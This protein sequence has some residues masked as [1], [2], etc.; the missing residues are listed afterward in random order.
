MSQNSA[1]RDE[2]QLAFW[3]TRRA[4]EWERGASSLIR[5]FRFAEA[6]IHIHE[7]IEFTVKALCR[8]MRVSFPKEHV[9]AVESLL[10]LSE[11]VGALWPESRVSILQSAPVLLGYSE[12]LRNVAR[13]GLEG[14]E[15]SS[16]SPELAFGRDYCSAGLSALSPL[17]TILTRVQLAARWGG[18]PVT[19]GVLDSRLEDSSIPCIP[20]WSKSCPSD[21]ASWSTILGPDYKVELVR[22]PDLDEHFAAVIDPF[23]ETYPEYDT[24][25][26]PCF[27]R[28]LSFIENGGLLVTSAGLP[29]YAA[30]DHK[31]GRDT[32]ITD[33][34]GYLIAQPPAPQPA[35]VVL[36]Y[37]LVVI[38]GTIPAKVFGIVPTINDGGVDEPLPLLMNRA[39]GAPTELVLPQGLPMQLP[40]FRPSRVLPPGATPILTATRPAVGE[41]YPMLLVSK[42]RGQVLVS[43]LNLDD[44]FTGSYFGTLVKAVVDWQR[45]RHG[46]KLPP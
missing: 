7:A 39:P 26:R 25:T 17:T 14:R 8:H 45:K 32:E 5:E 21:P 28:I 33:T 4:Y 11:R 30:W 9:P 34:Q 1:K 29:F 19:I 43:G 36:A 42:S 46:L 22:I 27:G 10:G 6:A 40:I 31:E 24:T 37:R 18:S 16:V 23:G 3:L 41:V 38:A 35:G 15:A 12:T 2:S 13:Y 44:N 20:R